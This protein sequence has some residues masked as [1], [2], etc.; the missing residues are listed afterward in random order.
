MMPSVYNPEKG[1]ER[2]GRCDDSMEKI[3]EARLKLIEDT[4]KTGINGEGLKAKAEALDVI[5]RAIQLSFNNGW[6]EN[7]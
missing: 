7:N 6:L 3:Y 1:G 2:M 4:P 5:E